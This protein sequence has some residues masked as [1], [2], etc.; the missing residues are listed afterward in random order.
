MPQDAM[1][2]ILEGVL[3]FEI[4]LMLKVFIYDKKYFGLTLLND[5]LESFIYGRTEARTKPLKVLKENKFL[6]TATW[7]CQVS[8]FLLCGIFLNGIS[9]QH[10]KHGH[11][12]QSYQ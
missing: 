9:L 6:V 1:H 12:L 7:D 10:H 5:R 3:P 2:V 4:K 11:L 8:F